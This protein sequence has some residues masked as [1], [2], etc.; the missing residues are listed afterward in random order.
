MHRNNLL[1]QLN[2]Y[3]AVNDEEEQSRLRT[4]EFVKTTSRCFERSNPQGHITG[5]AWLLDR[6]GRRVLLT[7]HRKLNRWLQLGGHADGNPDVLQV[8]IE[9]AQEESGII[10]IAPVT[11]NIFDVDVHLIP[12]R[13]NDPEH[14]HYDIRYLLRVTDSEEYKISH[15]SI[16]LKWVS[17]DEFSKIPIDRSVQ[18]LYEKWIHFRDPE[19]IHSDPDR[20]ISIAKSSFFLPS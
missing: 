4:I 18:R 12:A 6:T 2:V 13:K 11:E 8:A 16:D 14:F 5:S 3:R 15:E 20:G 1:T 10:D 7:H 17:P 9:E 19:T